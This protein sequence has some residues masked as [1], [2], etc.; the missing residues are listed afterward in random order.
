METAARLTIPSDR[1][2]LIWGAGRQNAGARV[3]QMI[4]IVQ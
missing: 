3:D 4:G 1:L 2:T